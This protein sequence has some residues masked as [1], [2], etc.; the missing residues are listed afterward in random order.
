MADNTGTPSPVDGGAWAQSLFSAIA[1]ALL[2]VAVDEQGVER[3][4]E[5]DS[6]LAREIASCSDD[7]SRHYL[8]ELPHHCTMLAVSMAD[9]CQSIAR[10]D[11][12]LPFSTGIVVRGLL[13][14]GA[15]LHWLSSPKISAV[16]RTRRAFLVYLRQLETQIRQMA[17]HAKRAPLSAPD[18]ALVDKGID[19]GWQ[20]LRLT[21]EGMA[22][23]GYELQTSKK[24]GAKFRLGT[25]KPSTSELVDTL[26]VEFY[27]TTSV[28]L[29]SLYSPIAHVD[30]E[31][32][33]SLLERSDFRDTPE[34]Q[35]FRYGLRDD[36]WMT[37]MLK[38]GACASLGCA[39]EWT[40]LA[41]PSMVVDF[42]A[43]AEGAL[44][45]LAGEDG[46]RVP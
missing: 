5:R 9:A 35:R 42:A 43:R 30:G 3:A 32:L 13:E 18:Q 20:L 1:D 33:G 38:P 29:Y 19:E 15:D 31:G 46:P 22:A 25:P 34:G 8:G 17:Q 11:P 45:A 4:I 14:A 21:A 24:P 23:A 27:G 28:N 16:E 39:A 26:L 2:A 10:L 37:R 40:A 12:G 41:Q 7:S 36:A 6:H 44:T